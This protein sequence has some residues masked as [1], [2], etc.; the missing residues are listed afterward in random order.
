MS[1][2]T[3]NLRVI[4]S[5]GYYNYIIVNFGSGETVATQEEHGQE[6]VAAPLFFKIFSQTDELRMP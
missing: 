1:P 5:R 4:R 6:N 3:M 2:S